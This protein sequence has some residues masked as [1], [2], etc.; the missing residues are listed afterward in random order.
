MKNRISWDD[1]VKNYSHKRDHVHTSAV[2]CRGQINVD[3]IVLYENH[4]MVGRVSRKFP[5][6]GFD[7]TILGRSKFT[8]L[9]DA[10]ENQLEKFSFSKNQYSSILAEYH[11]QDE[12]MFSDENI[13]YED[14][15]LYYFRKNLVLGFLH[16]TG[17]LIEPEDQ[18]FY[19]DIG[20]S[21][22]EGV[23]ANVYRLF[24]GVKSIIF[25]P[26]P[27]D[28]KT[29]N[30]LHKHNVKLL[31]ANDYKTI[32]NITKSSG[33]VKRSLSQKLTSSYWAPLADY[34]NKR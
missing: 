17:I 4:E 13:F 10:I 26:K 22:E 23:D 6:T 30:N 27:K 34:L 28:N 11:K 5:G 33:R 20:D 25:A 32:K 31:N 1:F 8:L 24:F 14:E 3:P 2:V 18:P 12:R 21:D 29:F 15:Y 19:I 7:K 16:K 9:T